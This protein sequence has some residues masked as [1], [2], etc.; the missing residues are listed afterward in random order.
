MI[1]VLGIAMSVLLAFGGGGAT[2]PQQDWDRLDV[3]DGPNPT[4][5]YGFYTEPSGQ[6]RMGRY[7]VFEEGARL[8]VRL[9]PYGRTG[10]ELPVR[11]HDREGGVLELGWEGKPGRTCRL[12]RQNERLFLGNCTEGLAVMPMAI[13]VADDSD[14]EW[15]G[16]HLPVSQEDTAILE[17]ARRILA[18]QEA[19]NRNGASS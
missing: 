15:M 16:V 7:Y 3:I 17:R 13:R 2:P 12:Q 11:R 19:R 8:R 10:V 14:A 6:L 4:L 9:A 5:R 18:G 1:P